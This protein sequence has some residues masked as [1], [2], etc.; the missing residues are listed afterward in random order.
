MYMDFACISIRRV[1]IQNDW[2]L[3]LFTYNIA[4][5]IVVSGQFRAVS[6]GKQKLRF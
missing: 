2:R 4:A 1:Y 5:K 6:G 3:L